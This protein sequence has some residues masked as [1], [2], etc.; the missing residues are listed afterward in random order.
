[1][2]RM[3][4]V[5]LARRADKPDPPSSNDNDTLPQ[6][7]TRRKGSLRMFNSLSR[8]VVPQQLLA[9]GSSSSASSGSAELRTPD[10]EELPRMRMLNQKGSWKSWLG[11]KKPQR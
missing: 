8:K 9:S 2:R 7:A 4:S 6:E 5:F 1:M 10:D 3:S 11:A